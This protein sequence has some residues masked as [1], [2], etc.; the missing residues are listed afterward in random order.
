MK[1]L[2]RWGDYNFGTS[3]YKIYRSTS[4]MNPAA[5]PPALA[6]VAAG[7][8]SYEDATVSDLTTYYYIISAVIGTQEVLAP[9]FSFYVDSS[10]LANIPTDW[11]ARF[12]MNEP[13]AVGTAT[14]VDVT[15]NFSGTY[16]DMTSVPSAKEGTALRYDTVG[17]KAN[18]SAAIG[19]NPTVFAISCWIYLTGG[20]T[21]AAFILAYRDQSTQLLQ[22]SIQSHKLALQTRS[23]STSLLTKNTQTVT[24][25]AWHHVV[26]NFNKSGTSELWYNNT[27]VDTD[28]RDYI[29]ELDSTL[30]LIGP[31]NAGSSDVHSITDMTLAFDLYTVYGRNLTPAEI[32]T[33]Y[34]E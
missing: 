2:L 32:E 25:G 22:F 17:Q 26:L 1:V 29:G 23:A 16:T 8:T 21:D 33:L 28:S 9:E 20:A 4:S 14:L 10:T 34:L 30:A 13:T 3:Q 6:T 7:T 18:I 11:R 5:L 31:Y 19:N 24:T 15:G 27:L 12:L